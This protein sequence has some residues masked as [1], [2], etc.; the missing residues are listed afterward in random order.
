MR[1]ASHH[2][3]LFVALGGGR[4]Q[5]QEESK[6]LYWLRYAVNTARHTAGRNGF[7]L[8]RNF[9]WEWWVQ[10]L[11]FRYKKAERSIFVFNRVELS[12][13][14]IEFR[15]ISLAMQNVQQPRNAPTMSLTHCPKLS[16]SSNQ[17]TTTCPPWQSLG[18]LTDG[19]LFTSCQRV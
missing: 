12:S 7:L 5:E 4:C 14:T 17:L 8:L 15:L 6:H 10:N 11:R 9:N 19:S 3:H 13:C 16:I 2:T 18:I 1:A